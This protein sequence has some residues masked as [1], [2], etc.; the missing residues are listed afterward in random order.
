MVGLGQAHG[1]PQRP[2]IAHRPRR[3]HPSAPTRPCLSGGAPS[4]APPRRRRGRPSRRRP[5]V[6]RR[7]RAG[8]RAVVS[9]CWTNRPRGLL[10]IGSL[11]LNCADAGSYRA[12]PA[13]R[14]LV[15]NA[16]AP[17]AFLGLHAARSERELHRDVVSSKGDRHAPPMDT[18]R[19]C[20]GSRPSPP[21][22]AA[23]T[24]VGHTAGA[25]ARHCS[26][27]KRTTTH[28]GATCSRRTGG[29]TAG[30]AAPRPNPAA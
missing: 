14:P 7:A 15:F 28:G 12:T 3:G 2:L 26:A 20:S 19:R 17:V 27:A 9:R 30:A 6:L 24:T 22:R 4:R 13:W 5:P 23:G 29:S 25:A 10:L 8:V 21:P 1:S 11:C 16:R 18:I